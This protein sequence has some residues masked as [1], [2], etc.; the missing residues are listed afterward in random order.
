[1]PEKNRSS[2]VESV[3][4]ATT[5]PVFECAVHKFKTKNLEEHQKHLDE[6]PHVLDSG[7]YPCKICKRVVTVI[8]DYIDNA[9][10]GSG[11][12]RETVKS[13]KKNMVMVN[14]RPMLSQIDGGLGVCEPCKKTL[15]E[16]LA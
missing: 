15:R 8:P 13:I 16:Q 7:T 14:K 2:M 1:M 4:S 5:S 6:V 9:D 10:E 3:S 11:F 12:T